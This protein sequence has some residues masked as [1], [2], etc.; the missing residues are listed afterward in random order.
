MITPPTP[1][2]QP[3]ATAVVSLP[4]DPKEI[5]RSQFIAFATGVVDEALFTNPPDAQT[6]AAARALLLSVGRM[7]SIEHLPRS[8]SRAGEGYAFKFTCEHG[9]AL[10]TF[11]VKDGKITGISFSRE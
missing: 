11:T 7:K 10:E 1:A 5:A 4:S 6:I 9:S 3:R 2:P 8:D